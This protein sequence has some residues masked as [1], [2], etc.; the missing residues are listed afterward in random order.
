MEAKHAI[1]A[2]L[3]AVLFLP[4]ALGASTVSVSSPVPNQLIT[5]DN[6]T[7]EFNP[8]STN[9]TAT[10]CFVNLNASPAVTYNGTALL[11]NATNEIEI[12]LLVTNVSTAY[13]YNVTCTFN[14]VN[15]SSAQ[16]TFRMYNPGTEPLPALVYLV[17]ICALAIG[18]MIALAGMAT[19]GGS[20]TAKA[21]A[22]VMLLV[23]FAIVFQMI[24]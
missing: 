2:I 7:I 3:A 17:I 21:M 24:A 15:V 1:L 4:S 5:H 22:I 8:S 13:E 20:M 10:G 6:V 18:L 23:I 9:Y 19:S 12:P 14:G 11:M 16:R